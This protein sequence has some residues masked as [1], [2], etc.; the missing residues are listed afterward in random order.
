M[1]MVILHYLLLQLLPVAISERPIRFV[2]FG[3]FVISN[4]LLITE[5]LL[6]QKEML[7]AKIL[8]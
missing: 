5:A 2:K 4:Y 6:M 1:R 8:H 7:L 3:K